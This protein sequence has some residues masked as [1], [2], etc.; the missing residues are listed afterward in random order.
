MTHS[1]RKCS[2]C[3]ADVI[4]C[5]SA[6]TKRPM[7]LDAAP[8][9]TGTICIVEPPSGGRVAHY[10]AGDDLEEAR[11]RGA[12]LHVSHFATCPNAK[13]HRKPSKGLGDGP[14]KR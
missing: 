11:A 9:P 12:E 1:T 3:P 14:G 10:L 4:W 6:T 5:M 2:S 13:K 7:P 8:S